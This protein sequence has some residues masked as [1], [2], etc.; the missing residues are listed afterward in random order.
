M[1]RRLGYTLD[2]QLMEAHLKLDV[3]QLESR[4][5]SSLFNKVN[6]IFRILLMIGENL[7]QSKP[8]TFYH[9]MDGFCTMYF[10]NHIFDVCFITTSVQKCNRSSPSQWI[11]VDRQDVLSIQS[12]S[13]YP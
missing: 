12:F 2:L 3:D 1:A 13:L 6:N 10:D 7:C 8:F 11:E 5:V 9:A 4:Q